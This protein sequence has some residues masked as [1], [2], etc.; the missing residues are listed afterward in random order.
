MS[1]EGMPLPRGDESP[2]DAMFFKM[3]RLEDWVRDLLSGMY[4]NCVYCGHRYGPR[5]HAVAAPGAPT[6]MA[7]ALTAHVSAC[8]S[9]PLSAARARIAELEAENEELRSQLSRGRE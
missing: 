1:I 4:V 8:P 3:K 7:A 6:D 5:E 9:H 2:S